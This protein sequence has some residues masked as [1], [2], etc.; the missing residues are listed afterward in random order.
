MAKNAK[1]NGTRSNST[2]REAH[3]RGVIEDWKKSGL[4]QVR[5]CHD[6]G[7]TRTGLAY[8]R[9]EIRIRDRMRFPETS[10]KNPRP[11]VPVNIVP[12]PSRISPGQVEIELENGRKIRVGP[13]IDSA[14]LRTLVEI[15]GSVRC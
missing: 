13:E 12:L 4:T 7:I 3:W 11:F 5:F 2:F 6:R 8:W 9:R 10:G 14:R 15:V 1:T